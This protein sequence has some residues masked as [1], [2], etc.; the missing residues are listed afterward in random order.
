MKHRRNSGRTR[1]LI[2]GGAFCTLV[3]VALVFEVFF[4][5][6]ESSGFLGTLRDGLKENALV[7]IAL[8]SFFS[9]LSAVVSAYYIYRSNKR[10]GN[11]KV[12]TEWRLYDPPYIRIEVRN[13]GNFV[14]Y[15]ENV[16]YIVRGR[17]RGDPASWAIAEIRPSRDL[18]EADPSFPMKLES[19][20]RKRFSI[21]PSKNPWWGIDLDKEEI[22]GVAIYTGRDYIL[23]AIPYFPPIYKFWEREPFA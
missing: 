23:K 9:M 5:V 1:R 3:S 20:E 19:G 21:M 13:E 17:A 7:I 10:Y 11:L 15:V 4:L 14:E 2:L 8:S 16:F 6:R 18:G 22:R 12:L